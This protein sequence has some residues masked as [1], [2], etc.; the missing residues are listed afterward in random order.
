[1]TSFLNRF[2]WG[3]L[4]AGWMLIVSAGQAKS[5]EAT[6]VTTYFPAQPVVTYV[7]QR[8]GLLG[9]RVVYRPVISYAVPAVPAAAAPAPVTSYLLPAGAVTTYYAPVAPAPITTYYAPAAPAAVTTYVVPAPVVTY[10]PPVI[11][12]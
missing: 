4:I 12:P 8:R 3:M 7:P 6:A 11:V 1:M 9:L 2:G 5:Q 10:Y